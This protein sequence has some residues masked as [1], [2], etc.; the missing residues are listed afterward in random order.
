M[1]EKLE[2][3][4]VAIL[5]MLKERHKGIV[6]ELLGSTT[7]RSVGEYRPCFGGNILNVTLTVTVTPQ[8]DKKQIV[9]YPLKPSK[10]DVLDQRKRNAL[11]GAAS[12]TFHVYYYPGIP[13]MN[14]TYSKP[15]GTIF[16]GDKLSAICESRTLVGG[17]LYWLLTTA[18][19]TYKW[20]SNHTAG[21]GNL[22]FWVLAITEEKG[23]IFF[24]K[25]EKS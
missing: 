21:G 18:E 8:M 23:I 6:V 2:K 12:P 25:R 15:D 24:N 7:D 22:P 10:K 16:G 4:T 5:D 14:V 17:S 19:E 1:K 20:E 13:T 9:C 11:N 3:P